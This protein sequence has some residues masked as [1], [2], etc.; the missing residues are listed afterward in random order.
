MSWTLALI[1]GVTLVN[2][3][4]DIVTASCVCQ[5]KT[6][7]KGLHLGPSPHPFHPVLS[8][9]NSVGQ[10]FGADHGGVLAQGRGGTGHCFA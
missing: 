3:V 6:I 4:S 1:G 2:V 10:T 9:C 5:C 8:L 7:Q